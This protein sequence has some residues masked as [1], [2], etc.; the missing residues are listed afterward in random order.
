M[1]LAL[2]RLAPNSPFRQRLILTLSV[3]SLF[4]Y[5]G[6]AGWNGYGETLLALSVVSLGV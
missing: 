5:F 4:G 1:P 2:A 3:V 6:L